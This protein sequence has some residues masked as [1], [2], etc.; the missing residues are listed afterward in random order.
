[1]DEQPGDRGA[2]RAD[3]REA[4]NLLLQ[5]TPI[6]ALLRDLVDLAASRLHASCPLTLCS[7]LR[8][9]TAASSDRRAEAMNE[10]QHSHLTGPSL[11]AISD[12]MPAVLMVEG[13]DD[14][15]QALTALSTDA[16]ARGVTAA[17]AAVA[18]VTGTPVR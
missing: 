17:T 14:E 1:M 16:A 6:T 3:A 11:G 9:S 7:D 8:L 18:I 5:L 4:E 12:G 13:G 15:E 2:G 10:W